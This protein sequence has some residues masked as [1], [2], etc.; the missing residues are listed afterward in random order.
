MAMFAKI[1][2]F[3]IFFFMCVSAIY[4]NRSAILRVAVI[5]A[6]ITCH[7][8]GALF[9]ESSGLALDTDLLIAELLAGFWLYFVAWLGTK[10]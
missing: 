2:L 5:L 6:P 4:W 8:V 9:V 3:V 1:S 10:G 7:V